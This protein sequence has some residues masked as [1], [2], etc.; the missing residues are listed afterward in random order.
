MTTFQASQLARSKRTPQREEIS[1][2]MPLNL[3]LGLK[4]LLLV[5]LSSVLM[6]ANMKATRSLHDY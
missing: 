2:E 5:I 3:K 6:V 4:E 1:R